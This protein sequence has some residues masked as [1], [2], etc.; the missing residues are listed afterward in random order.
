MERPRRGAVSPRLPSE[1]DERLA[2]ALDHLTDRQRA[3]AECPSLPLCIVAGAGSGKTRVLTLRAAARI[4]DG[5]AE[6]DHTVVCT[7]TRKASAELRDRLI[8]YGI[9]V[10]VPGPGRVP[11]PGVRVGTVH[12][13]ALTLI[14]RHC[15]DHGA[16]VPTVLEHRGPL[17]RSVTDSPAAAAV[18]GVEIAWAKAR[19]LT[20]DAYRS[21]IESG[22]RRAPGNA[23]EV[24]TGFAAYETALERRGAVDLD[25]LLVRAAQLLVADEAFATRMRWRY[26]HL[27][28]DEFQ[29][30]NPAQFRLIRALL[31]DSPD[32]CVVGDP[33]QAIY[34]WN[35]ADPT[36]LERLPQAFESLTVLQLADN[37]R[38]VPSIVELGDEVLGDLR[39]YRF[40]S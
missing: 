9:P 21:E 6:A 40:R 28:V 30:V 37:H 7:F 19:G 10:S 4:H 20:P 15:V 25:D 26:R 32:L 34:G 17:L 36:L 8:G 16:V 18:L 31:G 14:R 33:H 13:L 5:S 11:T 1:G 3:A 27:S 2:Q 22:R 29:D 24:V 23:E 38:S 12:Q 39:R 35:G